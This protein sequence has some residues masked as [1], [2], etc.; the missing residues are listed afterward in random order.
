MR[1]PAFRRSDIY[2]TFKVIVTNAKKQVFGKFSIKIDMS[3]NF[4]GKGEYWVVLKKSINKIL[5]V[6][7]Y[8]THR[9]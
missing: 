9:I 2:C 4:E 6:I 8:L 7:L 3:V 5:Y 1:T